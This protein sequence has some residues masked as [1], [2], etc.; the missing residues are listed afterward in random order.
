M[1]GKPIHLFILWRERDT[2]D[3]T[4]QTLRDAFLLN[5]G[6]N[7]PEHVKVSSVWIN[8]PNLLKPLD[9]AGLA[10]KDGQEFDKQIRKQHQMKLDAWRDFLKHEVI[11]SIDSTTK[12]YC[13]AIVEIGQT[14]RKEFILNKA[15]IE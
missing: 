15:S 9:T 5:E 7:F 10:P 3:V 1:Q 13:F 12:P 2:Y 6:E 8:D 11:A 4:C 14:K